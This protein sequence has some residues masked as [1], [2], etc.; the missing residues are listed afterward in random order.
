LFK[1]CVGDDFVIDVL[2]AL[3]GV[4][5][6]AGTI[7]AAE[8]YDVLAIRMRV[9]DPTHVVIEKLNSI[10]EHNC[11]F[12]AFLPAIRAVRE[13]LDWKRIRAATAD[14]DFAAAF[15]FLADRLGL[16]S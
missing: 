5:V 11:D 6:D 9:L 16:T 7:L 12:G 10:N 3:N 13:K 1:A 8:E 14:N 4:P 15:L 2:H